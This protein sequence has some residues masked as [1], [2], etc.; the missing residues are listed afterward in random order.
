MQIFGDCIKLK[1]NEEDKNGTINDGIFNTH[2]T[3][4]GF[5]P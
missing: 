5:M 3:S 2:E 4:F 1:Y